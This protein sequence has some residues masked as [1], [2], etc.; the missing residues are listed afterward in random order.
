MGPVGVGFECGHC[1][2]RWHGKTEKQFKLMRRLHAKKC[3]K[4]DVK[5]E[6]L[7]PPELIDCHKHGHDA[8]QLHEEGLKNAKKL[9]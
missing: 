2:Y 4:F 9:K 8:A 7:P 3:E 6:D 5:D 1:G